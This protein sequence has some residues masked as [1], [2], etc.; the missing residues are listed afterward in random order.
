M[1]A[2]SIYLLVL[3]ELRLPEA[4]QIDIQPRILRLIEGGRLLSRQALLGETVESLS[5]A[6]ADLLLLTG[7]SLEHSFNNDSSVACEFIALRHLFEQTPE[8]IPLGEL[9]SNLKTTY[10]FYALLCLL[11]LSRGYK[12]AHTANIMERASAMHQSNYAGFLADTFAATE[13]HNHLNYL[14]LYD[15]ALILSNM[16]KKEKSDKSKAGGHT[17]N[18]YCRTI[19]V[20]MAHSTWDEQKADGDPITQFTPMATDLHGYMTGEPS[21]FGYE[22]NEELPKIS[23]IIRWLKASDPPSE[24]SRSGSK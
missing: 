1:P 11:E 22:E 21:S 17:P 3:G 8:L 2:T 13:V 16:V 7:T 6:L 23:S 4:G 19:C 12:K 20:Q 10:Q 9:K 14:L 15:Q 24:A 18:A 5:L